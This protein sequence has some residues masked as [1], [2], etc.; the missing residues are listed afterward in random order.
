MTRSALIVAHGQPSDPAPAEADMAAMARAVA[1]QMPGWQ[2][3]AATLAAP[4]A[5]KTALDTPENPA[6][7]PFFMAD[8]WFIRTMLPKRLSEAGHE[9][10]RVLTPF[11]L[12]PDTHALAIRA[13][14]D[15]TGAHGWAEADTTLILA[16]HGSG[17]SPYPAEAARAIE[18]TI[19]NETQFAAI[20]TGFIEE[21]PSLTDAARDAGGKALCLPL[22]VARWGH[23]IDDIPDALDTV[24]FTGHLL[25]PIGTHP[26]VPALIAAAIQ[27]A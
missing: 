27:R 23:V 13:A 14:R 8:G 7:F 11:G 25:G 18:R 20:R 17:R 10:L 6:I 9:G 19:A 2:I 3:R 21:E 5:L 16:A 22:F 26:D 15:A 1:E 24:G 4:D 12:L